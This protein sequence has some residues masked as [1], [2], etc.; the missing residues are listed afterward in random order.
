MFHAVAGE[1]GLLGLAWLVSEDRW[2]VRWRTVAAGVVL[3]VAL[4]LLLTRFPPAIDAVLLLNR[5]ANAVQA[6]TAA[7]TGFVFGYLGGGPLP[8]APS[9]PGAGFILAFQALPLVLVISALAS[10]LFHWGVMQRI[11][12]AFAWLLRRVMGIGGPLALGAAVHVFVGMIEAPLLVRPY[13]A[14]M[15]RG[16][17]FALMTCGMAGVAGTVMVIYAEFLSALIP[18]ALGQ[19][20]TASV[21]STPAAV[22][23]AAVMV[24]FGPGS[25]AAVRLEREGATVSALDALVKGTLEGIPILAG[26]VAVLIVAVAMVALAN[27]VLGLLGHWGGAAI[28]LQRVFAWPFRPVMW[29]IGVPWGESRAAAGLMATKTVL[30]EFVAYRALAGM[31]AGAFDPR[32]R[33]ILTYALCGFANFGSL[34]IVIGGLGA[35][36]PERRAEVVALGLRSVLAGTIAT[37]MSGALAGWLVG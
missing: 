27:G 26:I 5:A 13:L 32:A 35:M 30:N 1:A 6:A 7:G 23:V 9:R 33:V 16:E 22:A 37:C 28:T 2:L 24:P 14:R 11:T 18:H 4:A 3:Q 15:S 31:G 10:L 17:L 34:G 29:L 21:I 36:V 25:D 19:I 8:F 20:L 12:A